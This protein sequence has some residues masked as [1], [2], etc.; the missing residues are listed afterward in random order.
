M[1]F[2]LSAEQRELTKAAVA[3]ARRELNQ[4]LMKREDAGEFPRDA[5]QACARFGI[6]GLPIPAELGGAGGDV[7][8]TALVMEALGYGC[9]DN[10]LLFSL[11]AQMWSVELPLATFGTPAQQQAYLPG[12][13]SGDIIGG[14]A[15][16]EPGSGSDAL[17]MRTRAERRGDHY[18]LNGA[19]QYITNAPVADVLLVYAS[20]QGRPGLPGLSA[21]L[22][23]AATPGLKV[24]SGF[25]KMGLRTSPTG[26]IAL[27]DCLV[28]A[29]SRL[30][31]EGAGMAIFN[32]SMEWERSCLFA[33][34]VGAMRRQLDACVAYARSREQFGQ[35][36]GK[37]Q[38]VAGKLA[39]MYV[40]LEAARLL[41]YRVAWLKQEGRSA[42]AEAAAAKLFTSEAWVRSSQDAIQTHGGFGYLKEAGIERDLRDAIAG[43]IYSGTSEIQRV[44]LAK[45]LGL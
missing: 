26:E 30:G 10:G 20:V 1:D 25:E 42:P 16:T 34:A 21:F 23:D 5:W 3:F 2:A 19:K 15:M 6:Q 13:V 12:M 40:R 29:E 38:S 27:T 18:L 22:V 44:V 4:D 36:I 45:M 39:D 35:P 17:H 41:I 8:T 31:P 24:S 37:F 28:P 7:L 9:Q 43:T 32:S 33:S 11:N 14:H